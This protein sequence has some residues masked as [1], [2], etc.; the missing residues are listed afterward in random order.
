MSNILDGFDQIADQI[1]ADRGHQLRAVSLAAPG[2]SPDEAAR[3]NT[4]ADKQ[5]LPFGV[6][7][8][9]LGEFEQRDRL[10]TVAAVGRE[11]PVVGDFLADPRRMALAGDD[12]AGLGELS[13]ALGRP[14]NS[15]AAQRRGFTGIMDRWLALPTNSPM[16]GILRAEAGTAFQ[17][18]DT[19]AVASLWHALTDT[20]DTTTQAPLRDA[21][22]GVRVT[23]A[24]GSDVT[25][26]ALAGFTDPL[27]VREQAK[28]SL[29]VVRQ[30]QADQQASAQR[31]G[32]RPTLGDFRDDAGAATEQFFAYY[33]NQGAQSLP[34]M[35][36]ALAT[37]RP[38]VGGAVM[39]ATTGAQTYAGLR[40]DGI[41][42]RTAGIAAAGT[43]L[44]E[45]ALGA[46]GLEAATA[47]GLRTL[48]TGPLV[49]AG[50]EAA[51][52]VAQIDLEDWARGSRTQLPER[53]SQTL[54]AAI[55]GF[56]FGLGE[57]A[58]S[59][60]I[61]PGNWQRTA[62]TFMEQGQRI[63]ASADA[64][65]RLRTATETAGKLK[66][67]TRSQADLEAF[68][69]Q[70]AADGESVYLP[71]DQ[72]RVLFQSD[73]GKLEELAGGADAL[74]EQLAV[75]DVVVPLP[76]WLA[77]VS[78]LPNRD[79]VLRHART[80]PD[81][82]SE[83][84]LDGFDPDAM[85]EQLAAQGPVDEAT[86]TVG[87]DSRQ[88]VFDDVYA[89]LAATR[90]MTPAAAE[91][92][93]KLWS[94]AFTRFGDM[95]GQDAFALYDRYMAGIN[96]G[97]AG[98]PP[99]RRK[100]RA[101]QRSEEEIDTDRDEQ[102]AAELFGQAPLDVEDSANQQTTT[103]TPPEGGVSDPGERGVMG[104]MVDAVR[105]L[106]Q[107][108]RVST[109]ALGREIIQRDGEQY[110]QRSGRWYLA[111]V[112][113]E[114]RD[115]LTLN[116]ASE[117][118]QRVGAEVVQDEPVEGQ[119]ATWS[120]ALSDAQA[121]ES[122][123]T[124]IL[125][126]QLTGEGTNRGEIAI[127]P[128]GKMAIRLFERADRST[129]LHESGHFFLEVYRDLAGADGAPQAM[130]DDFA[131][132]LEWF[133]VES[134]DAIGTDQHEQ[135]AR[136]FEAYLGE[137]KAPSVEL[138]SV[139]GQFKVWLLSIY[140]SLSRLNVE[141]TDDVRGVFD[142]ML[143]TEEEIEAALA[144]QEMTPIVS[145][146]TEA[147]ALGLSERQF[148]DYQA[149]VM[150]ANEEAKADVMSS[151]MKA[152]ERER[153]AWWKEEAENVRSEVA[154]EVE[155]NPAVR[156]WR[157]LRGARTLDGVEVPQELRVKLSKPALVAAY[158]EGILDQLEGM[159]RASGGVSVDEAA[160]LL[161]YPSGSSL[162]E[163]VQ[164]APRV[165]AGVDN[166]VQARMV[167]RHGEPNS[168]EAVREAAVRAVHSD[169]RIKLLEREM[170]MLSDLSGQPRPNRRKLRA[171]AY[172][173]IQKK[174]PRSLRPALYLAAERRAARDAMVA[175]S[176][177]DFAAALIAKRRQALNVAL[178][179]EARAAVEEFEGFTRYLRRFTVGS[180]R[181]TLGK[182][183]QEYLEQVDAILE[184]MEIKEV[185]GGEVKRRQRLAEWVEKQL[186]DG[187]PIDVPKRLLDDAMLV[188]IRDMP[189]EDLRQVVDTI[190]QI[191]HLAKLK[192]KLMLDA[193]ERDREEIDAEMAASVLAG[194]KDRAR[195]TGV[196]SLA[197]QAHEGLMQFRAI[198][199]GAT[200]IARELDGFKDSG[201]VWRN[202]VGVIRD[203]INNRVNPRL[204][205][206][207]ADLAGLYLKHYSKAELRQFQKGIALPEVGGDVWTKERM[208]SLALNWG[209]EGNREAVLVQA[210]GRLS[211]SQVQAIFRRLDSRDW[212]F[213][214]D[215][216]KQIDAYW[217]EI[218]ETQRR[219]TGIVPQ[220]VDRS[221]FFVDTA[222]GQQLTLPG[223][224]YPLKYEADTTKTVREEAEEYWNAVRLGRHAK[225]QTKNG[226][227]IERVGSGGRTVKLDLHVL[228]N[229]IRDVIRDLH[230]G[231]AVNY[232]HNVLNGQAFGEAIAETGTLELKKALDY[233]LKDVAAGEIGARALYE[234]AARSL[235][236]N[237]TA[238][239]LTYRLSS[240]LLQVTGVAQSVVVLGGAPM[241]EGVKR[242]TRYPRSSYRYVRQASPMMRARAESV[243]EAVQQVMDAKAGRLAAA[244]AAMI[245]WGY[246]LM[247]QV[248]S[249]VD[250]ATWLAAEQKGMTLF[251]GDV[252]RARQYADDVVV[253]AQGAQDFIDKTPLQRGTL[254]DSTRQA[255]WVKASTALAGYM[256][257]K[258]NVIYERTR[259][260]N[261]RRPE[262]ALK[263]GAHMVTLLVLENLL[264]A[265][266]TGKLPDDEDDD[267]I[268]DDLVAYLGTESFFGLIGSIPGLS[269]VSGSLRGY[270]SGG[271]VASAMEQVYDTYEQA[272]QG[273]MDKAA[274]KAGVNM[275][276]YASGIP[277]TQINRTIEVIQADRDGQDVTPFNY[278]TGQKPKP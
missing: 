215:V 64:T 223:G 82:F 33:G 227:T 198:Q 255:E 149:M 99:D 2:R 45:S 105:R 150:R 13:R 128:D 222:D 217:P 252:A 162:I 195:N 110:A 108:P 153:A 27:G 130:R 42:R 194:N 190:K 32:G 89:Q 72:A 47:P 193:Q 242:L 100:V 236:S 40:A 135:F 275:A 10:D 26:Q 238:M 147:A 85:G 25:A 141:L 221:P 214:Q 133:G 229:H 234:R 55:L 184:G 258:G 274:V 8:E 118:A 93:A 186:K 177:R 232:V 181:S 189:L 138:Q 160:M 73:M 200:D 208:L 142:R 239:V 265:A 88:Q 112:Q 209:N 87:G 97:R 74:R 151:L 145:D 71:A 182:A 67:G 86:D 5:G 166:E 248:Q 168:R 156:A 51:T 21:L 43:G 9:N 31:V 233:W 278:I 106:F 50:T 102:M 230:L 116:Q 165:L 187:N 61:D 111:D 18:G 90:Q 173:L 53:L 251:G 185:T 134:A 266:I 56:G 199:G 44:V 131:K 30:V 178:Y 154:A 201:A 140:R 231:D 1:E 29:D 196:R 3:A 240:A 20:L 84:E 267:G 4:L 103:Q 125:N 37:R 76:R 167:M 17:Q 164:T 129:F 69:A 123:S 205:T 16:R 94:A 144:R 98:T 241:L 237:F 78:Q 6:V 272:R 171:L 35:L 119:P 79:E 124:D 260:T 12:A 207:R 225:A 273:E 197:D 113:G 58:G 127:F 104:R 220:K 213:V 170:G 34:A 183:G 243:V 38:A 152:W 115:F 57:K 203:A 276:G 96:T 11:H 157:V 66:L 228:D 24:T 204:N 28:A 36:L 180:T 39:G 132:L 277:A 262:Q 271:V 143:A 126:Q 101:R 109:D 206:A 226:H 235:R 269:S 192:A 83:A 249:T 60:V 218:A 52:Q 259:R 117:E 146:A 46:T 211:L 91:A 191:E 210:Q 175:A 159:Y 19:S 270:G 48:I 114:P 80:A 261:F 62:E 122:L 65:A 77:V 216:W 163:A 70:A 256:L 188:N 244:R 59:V 120:V 263:W 179:A 7:A 41:D 202:T 23:D 254:G 81:G 174:P 172:A 212:E 247:G 137:G 49:E 264:A 63:L 224:Y 245:R 136:G 22:A 15:E 155:A 161:G 75:G 121:R 219:R 54:D 158:G 95:T 169:R 92:Q 148:A 139:F 246:Y 253:R 257:A 250:T 176:N 68:A 107:S 14:A 268:S